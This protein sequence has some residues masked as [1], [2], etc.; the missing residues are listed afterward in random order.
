MTKIT[1]N[2]VGSLIDTTTAQSTINNNFGTITTAFDNTLSRDGISPNTMGAEIDMN[3]FSIL[4]LPAPVGPANPLRLQDL[5]TFTGGGTVTN[6]P[7][8]GTTGQA[9]KKSSNA[10]FTTTW[11]NDVSSVGLAMPPQFTV[12]NSPVINT[13]TLTAAW[14]NQAQ[15]SVFAGPVSGGAGAPLFRTLTTADF[16]ASSTGTGNFVLQASPTLITPALGTPSSG[17]LVNCTGVTTAVGSITGLGT[18]VATALAINTGS[19]GSVQT[20]GAAANLGTTTITSNNGLSLAIGP[21]G[22]ASPAF[23]VDSS[24]GSLQAG[25]RVV[26]AITGGTI[27]VLTTDPGSNN[28]LAFNAK[29]TGTIGIGTVSTGAV[30]ITPPSTLTGAVTL[31]STINKVTLTPPATA[32]TL[33]IANNKT[34]TINNTLTFTGT[35]GVTIPFGTRTRQVFGSGSG[36]YTTPANVKYI[37]VRMLGGGGGGSGSGTTPGSGGNGGT[38]TFGSAFLTCAG[39]SGAV[40]AAGGAG[41]SPTGGDF[42][43]VGA[44][45][46]NGSGVTNSQG[47]SGGVSAFGSNGW[48]GPAGV[49]AGSAAGG[50]T[51]SGGGGAGC[52]ATSNSGAGGGAS[53]YQEKV[54]TSPLATYAYAIGAAGTAGTLGT[55]GAAGGAG[56]SGVIIV[57]E[58]YQ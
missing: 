21:N 44:S 56:G 2:N 25:L 24:A 39:G 28:N 34:A 37:Y 29:G 52:G 19:A 6:I 48:G 13:G 55:G 15:N 4:N 43:T 35:D 26:G 51:G 14:Q 5:S 8:G 9:L 45:G 23:Q 7:T 41:S 12:T 27:N 36:T 54:I 53:G 40:G 22:A 17:N 49:A 20:Q 32:A 38:T 11:G 42:N 33:T 50:S 47:G 1:L 57:D 31:G 46:Q 3:G 30:T 10:N 58:F 18:G 16:V